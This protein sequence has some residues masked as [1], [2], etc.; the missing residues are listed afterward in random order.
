MVWRALGVS[1]EGEKASGSRVSQDEEE[2]REAEA[3]PARRAVGSRRSPRSTRARRVTPIIW[4]PQASMM[5]MRGLYLLTLLVLSYVRER[6][7]TERV[8]SCTSSGF[9]RPAVKNMNYN[10]T[11]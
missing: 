4:E 8:I 5:S 1:S 11:H 7:I 3:S 2:G 9:H 6:R 10:V